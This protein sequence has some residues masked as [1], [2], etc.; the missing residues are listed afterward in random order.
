M[1]FFSRKN[2]IFISLNEEDLLNNSESK[3]QADIENT[4]PTREGIQVTVS[5]KSVN[6]VLLGNLA[7][8]LRFS[9]M[10]RKSNCSIYLVASK[11]IIE[12][13]KSLN[14]HDFFDSL[15]TSEL[16]NG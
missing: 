11:N 9:M 1:N 6:K 2:K 4:L 3:F 13:F 7:I 15:I 16:D 8:I 14:F 12:D 5:L 10:V